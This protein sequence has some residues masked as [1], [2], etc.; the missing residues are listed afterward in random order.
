MARER[1]IFRDCY[2]MLLANLEKTNWESI[3]PAIDEMVHHK[4][5]SDKNDQLLCTSL[6]AVI[7]DHLSR[8]GNT[9]AKQ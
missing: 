2:N 5:K 6:C 7:V 1:E 4:Y 3:P 9:N 8:K